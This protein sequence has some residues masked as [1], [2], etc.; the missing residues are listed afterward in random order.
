MLYYSKWK[1]SAHVR[2]GFFFFDQQTDQQT[3][4]RTDKPS[5]RDAMAASK[6]S[7]IAAIDVGGEATM[8]VYHHF[9][10]YL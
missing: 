5:Y 4:R 10:L 3:D 9:Y 2:L 1:S 6:N 7:I 8:I